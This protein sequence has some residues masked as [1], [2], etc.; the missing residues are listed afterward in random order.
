MASL[1]ASLLCPRV[2]SCW[3]SMSVFDVFL[4]H[5]DMHWRGSNSACV[6]PD[7]CSSA[8]QDCVWL[9]VRQ[10]VLFQPPTPEESHLIKIC[11]SRVNIPRRRD[12][13]C[14][15]APLSADLPLESQT[16]SHETAKK[17]REIN[18]DDTGRQ[19]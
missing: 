15:A 13:P 7:G 1:V 8:Y 19:N 3:R 17:Q 11:Y 16:F 10:R 5:A 4:P 14:S 2:I 9:R 6:L 12:F 18:V